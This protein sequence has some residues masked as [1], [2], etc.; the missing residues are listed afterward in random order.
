[1]S[2][3]NFTSSAE[4]IDLSTIQP[5]PWNNEQPFLVDDFISNFRFK[6]TPSHLGHFL[7]NLFQ[8]EVLGNLEIVH[9][10]GRLVSASVL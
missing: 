3:A 1:M 2:L 4:Y 5:E 8:V 7:N 9:V 10:D 6:K